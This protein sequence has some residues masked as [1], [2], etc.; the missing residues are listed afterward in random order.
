[1]ACQPQ[2]VLRTAAGIICSN[3]L[4][5]RVVKT[6]NPFAIY[7]LLLLVTGGG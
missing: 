1:M 2:H 5:R 4:A 3:G 6:S 7:L